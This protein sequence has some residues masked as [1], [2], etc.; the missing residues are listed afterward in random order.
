[1]LFTDA[2]DG[3][4]G[5]RVNHECEHRVALCLLL[6]PTGNEQLSAPELSLE[7]GGW[8]VKLIN[9]Q[10]WRNLL[11]K[12]SW[13]SINCLQLIQ[14]K[15]YSWKIQ[16]CCPLFPHW[17]VAERQEPPG[18]ELRLGKVKGQEEDFT[19]CF[20]PK[21]GWRTPQGVQFWI[22]SQQVSYSMFPV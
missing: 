2:E 18:T 21:E 20:Q 10:I 9:L 12:F 16:K 4:R 11:I 17:P 8:K 6:S 5:D 14:P 22:Y 19:Y 1:M 13:Q 15:F 3:M 7:R